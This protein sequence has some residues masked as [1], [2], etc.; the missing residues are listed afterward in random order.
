MLTL[1]IPWHTPCVSVRLCTQY[2][3]GNN[4]KLW[5]FESLS[6][7]IEGNKPWHQDITRT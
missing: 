1:C 4:N 3:Y 6:I 7:G 2:P 5:P